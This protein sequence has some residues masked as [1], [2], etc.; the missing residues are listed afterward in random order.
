MYVSVSFRTLFVAFLPKTKK[1]RN[2]ITPGITTP[3]SS[4]PVLEKRG[5]GEDIV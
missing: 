3:P 2:V 4:A 5:R 1:K